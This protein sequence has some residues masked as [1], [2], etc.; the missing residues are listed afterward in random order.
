MTDT[1]SGAER[2]RL[3]GERSVPGGESPARTGARVVDAGT[4]DDRR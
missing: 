4:R 2:D 1:P 3:D